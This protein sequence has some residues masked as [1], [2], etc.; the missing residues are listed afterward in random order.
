ML[1]NYIHVIQDEMSVW[2]LDDS[3]ASFSIISET[4]RQQL[5]ITNTTG[6]RG[7]VLKVADGK[8]VQPVGRCTI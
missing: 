8:N 4:F 2:A 5:K 3:G 1:G 7:T 6:A